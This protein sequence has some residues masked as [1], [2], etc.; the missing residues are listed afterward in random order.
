MKRLLALAMIALLA[1]PASG[2]IGTSD[3]VFTDDHPDGAVDTAPVATENQAQTQPNVTRTQLELPGDARHNAT[4]VSLDLGTAIAVDDG[5]LASEYQVRV[6]ERRLASADDDA[7]LV[8]RFTDRVEAR[9]DVL[10]DRERAAS[11]AYANGDI[12][13]REF[14]RRLA[15]IGAEANQLEE[16]LRTLRA[17]TERRDT[18]D[19]IDSL[20]FRLR[21]SHSPSHDAFER[22]FRGDRVSDVSVAATPEGYVLGLLNRSQETFHRHAVRF[23]NRNPTG[24]VTLERPTEGFDRVRELYPETNSKDV[25]I[26][27]GRYQNDAGLIRIEVT[28]P[29]GPVTLYVDTATT[30]V[31]YETRTLDVEAMPRSTVVNRTTDGVRIVVERTFDNGPA[32]V[33]AFDADTG[34]PTGVTLAVDGRDVGGTGVNGE[35]WYVAPPGAYQL[36]VSDGE[37]RFNVTVPAE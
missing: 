32:L 5:Q 34:E 23:D 20:E 31:F 13:N 28:Y 11:R 4:E 8:D 30:D 7:R 10:R 37:E 16:Q 27:S 24:T 22:G 1:T 18:I 2:A 3:A 35:R 14:A 26:T 9:I 12:S 21:P 29:E 15:L 19:R 6:D 17:T 33:K 25:F 36:S